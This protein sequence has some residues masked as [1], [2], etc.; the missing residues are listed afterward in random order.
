MLAV[1]MPI[2]DFFRIFKPEKG[3]ANSGS[4]LLGCSEK[5]LPRSTT[6]F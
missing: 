3:E 4:C 2:E 6:I 1:F 5:T